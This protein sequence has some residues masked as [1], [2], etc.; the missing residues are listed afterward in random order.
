M[1]VRIRFLEAKSVGPLADFVD[2]G[3]RGPYGG[4]F[5]KQFLV[6]IVCQM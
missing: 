2:Q 1:V 3:E 6:K 5:E 4:A